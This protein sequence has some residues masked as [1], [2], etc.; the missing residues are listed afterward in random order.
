M[1]RDPNFEDL[2][3]TRVSLNDVSNSFLTY[4]MTPGNDERD[5]QVAREKLVS[6]VLS[7]F[8]RNRKK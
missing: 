3:T 8:P 1:E 6:D 5:V 2:N 4:M 7:M